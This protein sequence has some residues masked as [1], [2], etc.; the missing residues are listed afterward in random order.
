MTETNIVIARMS[1]FVRSLSRSHKRLVLMLLD[2]VI[3]AF[4]LWAAVSLR[5]GDLWPAEIWSH[6]WWL[7]IL[8]P[9]GTVWIFYQMRVYRQ[10]LRSAGLRSAL[11]ISQAAVIAT[12]GFVV[13]GFFFKI[14]PIPRSTPLIFLFVS[15]TLLIGLRWV[16]QIIYESILRRNALKNPVIIYGAGAAGIQ[17]LNALKASDDY[18]AVAFIDDD[19]AMKSSLVVGRRVYPPEKIDYLIQRYDVH[20]VFLAMPS[21]S[22]SRK[23]Q[24]LIFLSERR[25]RVK[26]IPPIE[27]MINLA[28]GDAKLRTIEIEDLVGREAVAPSL[29]LFECV[30]DKNVLITGAGGSIGSE[31]R[32]QIVAR[33]PRSIVLY[34][35][36]EFALYSIDQELRSYPEARS[37]AIIPVLGSVCNG[38]RLAEKITKHRIQTLFHA[39][40][41]KHVPL[42]EANPLEGV[43]NNTIGTYEVAR[44]AVENGVERAILVSTDKAVRPTN[45]MG[46]SKRLAELAF[47]YWQGTANKTVLCMVRFGNVMGSSGSVIPL[48]KKQIEQGGPVTITHPDIVRYFMTIP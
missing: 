45:V 36:S 43:R 33:A 37:I 28:A 2:F 27:D 8:L 15:V 14:V 30:R 25:L 7:L 29:D 19:S 12:L 17:L 21:V 22:N 44:A 10:I 32:R 6:V 31:L 39:A 11:Q 34:E 26:E 35:M 1:A 13:I 42:V 18:S 47:Q 48:F 24:I 20:N 3:V 38:Q 40:A 5:L 23:R 41:Y 9:L 46:A 16:A 4:S